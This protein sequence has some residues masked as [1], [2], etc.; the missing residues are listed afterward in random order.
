MIDI[1]NLDRENADAFSLSVMSGGPS[2]GNNTR[3][4]LLSWRN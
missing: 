2:I 4:T 1:T 3:G